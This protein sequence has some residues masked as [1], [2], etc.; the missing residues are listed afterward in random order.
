MFAQCAQITHM[1]NMDEGSG[2]D[3][4]SSPTADYLLC[5]SLTQILLSVSFQILHVNE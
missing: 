1:M 3:V 5:F 4:W 2:G